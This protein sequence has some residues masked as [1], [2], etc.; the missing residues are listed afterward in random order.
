G[1][2]PRK[3]LQTLLILRVVAMTVLLLC[4]FR[5]VLSF[6]KTLSKKTGLLMLLDTSK[7][8]SI[9]DFPNLPGRLERVKGALFQDRGLIKRV[10]NEFDLAWHSFSSYTK[11]LE[12]RKDITATEPVGDTTDMA[13][14][15]KEAIGQRERGGL[16]GVLLFTDGVDNVTNDPTQAL[17][18]LGV[19]VYPVGVGSKLIEQKN[20][21]DILISK[22]EAKRTVSVKVAT[23]IKVF[24]EAI[25][26]GDNVVPILLK[27]D[28]LEVAR[29]KIVL[30]NKQ[31]NQVVS[32][33]YTPDQ[34][35]QFTFE[36]SIPTDPAE[37]IRENN[38]NTFPVL[39]T[40]PKIN[41]LYVEAKLRWEYKFLRRTLQQDPNID[42]ASLVKTGPTTFYQQDAIES[43]KLE[44][45]PKTKELMR[46]FDV[47]IIGDVDRS[48]FTNE[49]FANLKA[50]V[51][52]GTAFLMIGGYGSFGPGG[53]TGTAVEEILPVTMGGR[54]IGQEKDP[55]LI[56]VTDEGMV[57]P[58]F[59]GCQQFFTVGVR[60]AEKVVPELLGCN[61]VEKGKPGASLLAV[62]PTKKTKDGAPLVVLAVQKYGN[63]RTAAFT[64]DTT[65]RWYFPLRGMGKES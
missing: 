58:V 12:S 4:L 38:A 11:K 35:G 41:V 18:A 19:P 37:R 54:D 50:A 47:I 15:V 36:A 27:R 20:F 40:D 9:C 56:K 2:V 16:T 13:R 52:E 10:E 8:M 55:F 43:I 6:Q 59:A 48:H 14:A 33:K 51:S 46:K 25:G 49:H 17:A 64:V 30:D 60:A 28:G 63:G 34:T 24:V 57:H 31:G 5:P 22:V 32:I 62:H 44:G 1:A 45:F 61:L 53:F 26:F 7:S 65:W 29:E 42:L 3:Q 23:E 21:K 39:V